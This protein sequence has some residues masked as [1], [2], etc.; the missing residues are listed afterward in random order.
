MSVEDETWDRPVCEWCKRVI[1][2]G[3]KR[4]HW[5]GV[6]MTKRF[7]IGDQDVHGGVGMRHGPAGFD[8]IVKIHGSTAD[9]RIYSLD[10]SGHIE[11]THRWSGTCWVPSSAPH[12]EADSQNW[13]QSVSERI[14]QEVVSVFGLQRVTSEWEVETVDGALALTI[15]IKPRT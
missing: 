7:A 10:P 9:S 13:S 12:T 14:F 11:E 2:Y 5:H 3:E 6:C 8:D 15:K 1:P 4:F